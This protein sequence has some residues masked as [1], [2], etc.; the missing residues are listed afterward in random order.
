MR[1]TSSRPISTTSIP[2]TRR[3]TSRCRAAPPAAASLKL[4]ARLVYKP[5]FLPAA[6]ML[7]GKPSTATSTTPCPREVRLKNTL[8]VAM[9]LDNSGS[10]TTLGTGSGQKRI[11]LLKQ[12]AK[13]LVDTLAAAG[14]ADQADRQAGPVHARALRGLGQCRRRTT[15]TPH[16]WTSYGL[17]P[18]HQREFRLVDAERRRQIRAEDQ[19]HLVQ[20]G[21]RLGRARKA[22]CCPASRSTGHEGGHQPRA[23]RR[24]QGIVCTKY[25]SN[26]TCRDSHWRIRLQ[27]HIRTASP[28][29]RAASRSRP[30]P[31]NVNDAPAS[32][33]PN[34][35]GIGF[36]DPATM[37]VPMFAPDEPGDRWDVTQDPTS[38]RPT[39][40]SATNNWW[41]DGTD[42]HLRARRGSP[43]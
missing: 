36:G 18:I 3:S 32:G 31:Y 19:R 8:E 5:Y 25:R 43:T 42:E 17:S 10:M 12:A 11:D 21:H 28:A 30:Y 34:N 20:E 37:F 33:G 1:S 41:N 14:G 35:T 40:Y 9:V 16:G 13:Q 23:G 4:C 15:P 26:D 27:R 29:G 24:Q 6:A 22:R 38:R 2:P 7:I 39:I